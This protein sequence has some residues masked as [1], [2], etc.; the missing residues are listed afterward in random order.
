MLSFLPQGAAVCPNGGPVVPL[1]PKNLLHVFVEKHNHLCGRLLL[2][3][4][5]ALH[6]GRVDLNLTPPAQVEQ[7]G[8][9]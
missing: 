8:K 2:L 9:D 4:H 3:A 1:G 7:V 5:G 6:G